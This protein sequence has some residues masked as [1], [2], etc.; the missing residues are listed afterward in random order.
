[1]GL[2]SSA[3]RSSCSCSCSCENSNPN[4]NPNPINFKIIKYLV[5]NQFIIVDINYPDAT[6]YE[7]NKILVFSNVSP[8]NLLNMK[9]IDPHFCEEQTHPS[10]VARF[11]PTPRGWD[12]AIQFCEACKVLINRKPSIINDEDEEFWI[13]PHKNM[14][15]KSKYSRKEAEIFALGMETSEYCI[16][17]ENFPYCYDCHNCKNCIT[18]ALCYE[19]VDCEECSKCTS[20]TGSKFLSEINKTSQC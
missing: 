6:N 13:D 19:C 20:C 12:M 3:R 15:S 1:M 8:E 7:G 5:V 16:N 17:C 18:C 11:V 14:W 10:P 2:Y 9:F 4:P